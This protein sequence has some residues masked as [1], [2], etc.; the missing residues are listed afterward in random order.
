[1]KVL[2]F[3]D[4]IEDPS[5]EITHLGR[6]YAKLP[7]NFRVSR[8]LILSHIYGFTEEGLI[9]AAC[10]SVRSPFE[11]STRPS[12]DS[13]SQKL[14]YADST[15]SDT[16]SSLFLYRE[17]KYE[18]ETNQWNFKQ[19]RRWENEHFVNR[20]TLEE[21]EDLISQLVKRLKENGFSIT[22]SVIIDNEDEGDDGEEEEGN[23][24]EDDDD[25]NKV[26]GG[27]EERIDDIN[28]RGRSRYNDYTDKGRG[29]SRSLSPIQKSIKKDDRLMLIS[30]LFGSFYPNYIQT[31][32]KDERAWSFACNHYDTLDYDPTRTIEVLQYG[33][34]KLL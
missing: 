31:E 1:M 12:L 25:N 19:Q 5:G 4:N 20:K 29:N 9:M 21:I 28:E 30:I 8:M 11:Y 24:E 13:F 17:W 22:K 18:K 23:E 3:E 26:E 6:I 33:I 32:F 7:L 14:E 16:L 10:M 2:D 15:S 34:I 27:I